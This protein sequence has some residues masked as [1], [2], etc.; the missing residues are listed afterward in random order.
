MPCNNTY[1]PSTTPIQQKSNPIKTWIPHIYT[2]PNIPYNHIPQ[3]TQYTYH[4]SHILYKAHTIPPHATPCIQYHICS[5]S[6][7]HQSHTLY[8]DIHHTT[9]HINLPHTTH[10]YNAIILYTHTPCIPHITHATHKNKLYT[11]TYQYIKT[12]I[13]HT[14]KYHTLHINACTTTS[15]ILYIIYTYTSYTVHPTYHAYILLTTY[16]VNTYYMHHTYLSSYIHTMCSHST[17]HIT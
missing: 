5:I 8:M 6:N 4:T 7:I 9:T 3:H 13:H 14:C 2:I 15:H 11:H 1:M 12:N 10:I 17:W 16:H